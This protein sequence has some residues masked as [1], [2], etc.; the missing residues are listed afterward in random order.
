I[1]ANQGAGTVSLYTFDQNGKLTLA[2]APV[3]A[4]TAPGSV[5]V[6]SSGKLVYV[7]DSAGNAVVAF[8]LS[9]NTLSAV[10]GSP[11]AAGTAPVHVRVASSNLFVV[12]AGSNN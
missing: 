5:D 3:A 12:N 6:D 11:F 2:G 1:V 8:T 10:A 9:G 4:G 7:A